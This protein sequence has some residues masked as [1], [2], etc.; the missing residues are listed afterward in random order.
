MNE[1]VNI[2][3]DIPLFSGLPEDQLRSIKQ[4]AVEKKVNKGE[5]RV[6]DFMSPSRGA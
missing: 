2:I 4:I 5:M 3:S 1:I 6:K